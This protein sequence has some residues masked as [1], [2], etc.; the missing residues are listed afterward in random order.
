MHD[1]G[2]AFKGLWRRFTYPIIKI[3]NRK[4]V[5]YAAKIAEKANQINYKEMAQ[6]SDN[7]LKD[8][9]RSKS[10]FNRINPIRYVYRL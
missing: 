6:D 3:K 9:K 2:I 4:T 8:S 5:R 1:I 10:L 7:N